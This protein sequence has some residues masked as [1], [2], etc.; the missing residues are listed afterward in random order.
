MVLSF[1]CTP[2][3]LWTKLNDI[4][5]SPIYSFY[6][7]TNLRYNSAHLNNRLLQYLSFGLM[8]VDENG[9]ICHYRIDLFWLK[10]IAIRIY[11]AEI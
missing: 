1:I 2:A 5:A 8:K 4:F 10:F 11:L 9:G 6:F 7:V 3:W